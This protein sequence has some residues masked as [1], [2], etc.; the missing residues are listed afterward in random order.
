[1]GSEVTALGD[2]VPLEN[3]EDKERS[4]G[5]MAYGGT[6]CINPACSRTIVQILRTISRGRRPAGFQTQIYTLMVLNYAR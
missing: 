4:L 2:M 6:I 5:D 1:M 3:D